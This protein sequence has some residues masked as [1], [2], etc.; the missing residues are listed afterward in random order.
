[1]AQQLGN[2][3]HYYSRNYKYYGINKIQD[4]NYGS[5][6][7]SAAYYNKIIDRAKQKIVSSSQKSHL[8]CSTL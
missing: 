6:N 4:G 1:M 7:V 8:K 2:Y 5:N 3:I